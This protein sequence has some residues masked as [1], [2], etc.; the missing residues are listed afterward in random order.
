MI[1]RLHYFP[2]MCSLAAIAAFE[3]AGAE[4]QPI[5]QD[6]AGDRSNLRALSARGQIPILET[7]D[8]VITDTLAILY[9]LN[10]RHRDAIILPHQPVALV[11]A[12]SKIAWFSSHLHI[13]RRRYFRPELFGA[14]TEVAAHMREVAYPIYWSGL[15]MIDT[16]LRDGGLGCRGVEAYALLFYHWATSDAMPVGELKHYTAL[17]RQ[18]MENKG[19][20]HAL[21]LHASP[22]L[23]E[24]VWPTD[25]PV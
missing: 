18:L 13:V 10:L 14:P 22:L 20:R 9:W 25:R 16:W 8:G 7:D 24:G 11:T 21:T 6:M 3:L 12:L 5:F 19:V 2:P 17:V 1:P 23:A 4:Y 15:V